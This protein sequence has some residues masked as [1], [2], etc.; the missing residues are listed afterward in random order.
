M[1]FY[2]VIK[3]SRFSANLKM[4]VGVEK[5]HETVSLN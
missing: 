3:D 5:N 4:P 1:R 2:L